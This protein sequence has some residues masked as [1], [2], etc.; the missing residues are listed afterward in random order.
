MKRPQ[1]ALI[2]PGTAEPD[3]PGAATT[4]TTA[5]AAPVPPAET[6]RQAPRHRRYV[7]VLPSEAAARLEAV[8]SDACREPEQ[9]L[10]FYARR[11]L[12]R[13]PGAAAVGSGR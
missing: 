4:R 5:G 6:R 10:E 3:R 8:A 9:Q 13:A 2:P 1:L 11:A 7:I 12:A